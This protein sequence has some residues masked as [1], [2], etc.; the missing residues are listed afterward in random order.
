MQS[1]QRS[2]SNLPNEL[3]L[4][5]ASFLPPVALQ[6]LALANRHFNNL[7]EKPELPQ[8]LYS[9]RAYRSELFELLQ[10]WFPDRYRL[11]RSCLRFKTHS[12][13]SLWNGSHCPECSVESVESSYAWESR[14]SL[15]F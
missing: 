4:H 13:I 8:D 9:Q 10:T 11:C 15:G 2:L 6:C 7:L 5:I 3:Q 14:F 12:D 1:S